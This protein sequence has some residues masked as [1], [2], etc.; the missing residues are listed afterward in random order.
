MITNVLPRL[1]WFTVYTYC[2]FFINIDQIAPAYNT[3]AQLR[4]A[5]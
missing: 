5:V 2:I 4:Y 1:L 3:G